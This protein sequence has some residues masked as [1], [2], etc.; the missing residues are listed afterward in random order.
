MAL[1]LS[2]PGV[3]LAQGQQGSGSPYSAHSLGDLAGTGQVTLAGLGGLAVTVADPFSVARANPATYCLLHH[4]SYEMG[5]TVRW[6]RMTIGEESGRGRNTRLLGFSLGVPFAKGRWGMALGLQPFSTVA[7]KFEDRQQVDGGALRNEYTGSGGVNRAYLGFGRTLWQRR[8]STGLRSRLS[9]GA[10]FEF[11]FGTVDDTRKA[12]YP[13]GSGY[14]HSSVVSSLVLRAPTGTLGLMQSGQL[15]T[16]AGAEKRH[17]ERLA[18][19]SAKDKRDEMDWLNAGRDPAERRPSKAPKPRREALR[20]RAGVGVDLPAGFTA[21]HSSLATSFRLS[22]TV[23]NPIDTAQRIDGAFGTLSL[24][25]GLAAGFGIENNRWALAAE[26]HHRDWSALRSDVEG[27]ALST[28]LRAATTYSVGASFRPA[29][30]Q[31]GSFLK[32][33]TYRAGARYTQDPIALRDQ[34]ISQFGM[35]FG[36]SLPIAG[37]STRSRIN[38]AVEHGQRGTTEAGLLSE[39]YTNLHIGVTITPDLREQWFKKRRID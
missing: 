37:A 5:A 1:A 31:G 32:R 9:A 6:T 35:S 17:K 4:T 14:Y 21:Q 19:Y 18:R 8:D 11:L 16:M 3:A 10:N 34:A 36:C 7:Y 29:G 33:T 22:G 13:L 25:F 38:L 26:L 24:P 20:W 2:M 27:Y 30:Q 39:R 23:E 12:Y 15:V 28:D